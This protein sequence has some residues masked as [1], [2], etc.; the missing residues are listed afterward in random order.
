MAKN[1]ITLELKIVDLE[2]FKE[3]VEALA[4]NFDDL[5]EKVKERLIKF[6][7]DKAT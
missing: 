6:Y 5:P 4:E 1:N 2:E 3:L 7:G